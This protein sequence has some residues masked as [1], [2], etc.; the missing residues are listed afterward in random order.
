[1]EWIKNNLPRIRE[2]AA[3]TLSKL[4]ELDDDKQRSSFLADQYKLMPNKTRAMLQP[5][6]ILVNIL[7]SA[8]AAVQI[9]ER[10]YTEDQAR[11]IL[12]N[13]EILRKHGDAKLSDIFHAD[14]RLLARC[15][16]PIRPEHGAKDHQIK[17]DKTGQ[18]YN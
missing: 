7:N 13:H 4:S 3:R 6:N 10:P 14:L 9:T 18:C 11:T 1:M 5:A 16:Q 8:A 15:P 12:N 2:C 17:D